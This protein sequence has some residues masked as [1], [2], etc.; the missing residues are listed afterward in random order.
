MAIIWDFHV[1]DDI[2][3]PMAFLKGAAEA[4]KKV[5]SDPDD[6]YSKGDSWDQWRGKIKAFV[7]EHIENLKHSPVKLGEE[8]PTCRQPGSKCRRL[9]AALH[10]LR[11]RR[12]PTPPNRTKFYGSI[13]PA[14]MVRHRFFVFVY[15]PLNQALT[16]P[17]LQ[18][19]S[20]SL[21]SKTEKTS[22]RKS[23]RQ[24]LFEFPRTVP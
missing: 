5:Y 15:L 10:R 11:S 13:G 8:E 22:Q 18:V 6:P 7:E 4:M 19:Q 17:P 21:L 20:S 14:T 2:Q 9:F 1:D 23:S 12:Y 24:A 16:L 3:R